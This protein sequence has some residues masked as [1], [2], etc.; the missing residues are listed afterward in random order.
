MVPKPPSGI[1]GVEA[2]QKQPA[3]HVSTRY[4]NR[5]HMYPTP[6]RQPILHHSSENTTTTTVEWQEIADDPDISKYTSSCTT[7][8]GATSTTLLVSITNNYTNLQQ[9]ERTIN[10]QAVSFPGR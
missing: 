7:A 3:P 1:T 10:N 2:A 5:A 8:K 6:E 9:V 4:A